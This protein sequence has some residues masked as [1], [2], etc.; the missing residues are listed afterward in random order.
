MQITKNVPVPLKSTR[1]APSKRRYPFD[2]MEVGDMFFVPRDKNNM[3]T[4]ASTVSK[5]L[6]RKHVTRLLW[7]KESVEGW[8]P[9][10]KGEGGAVLGVGV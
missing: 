7:M 5:Q 2:E 6:G 9:A 1:T 4:H 3:S 10:E 8:V